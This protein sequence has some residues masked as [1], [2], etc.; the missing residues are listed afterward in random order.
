VVKDQDAEETG[1]TYWPVSNRQ[2]P[3]KPYCHPVLEPQLGDL[4]GEVYSLRRGQRRFLN[5]LLEDPMPKR[6]AAAAAIRYTDARRWLRD[7]AFCQAYREAVAAQQE[8]ASDRY[9]GMVNKALAV[10]DR[11]MDCEDPMVAL[12]AADMTLKHSLAGKASESARPQGDVRITEIVVQLPQAT[13][14][15]WAPPPAPPALEG[16]VVADS[17]QCG[18]EQCGSEQWAVDSEQATSGSEPL[19]TAHRSPPTTA[20]PL[21]TAHRSLITTSPLTIVVEE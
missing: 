12:K 13:A 9:K 3:A 2:R 8:L 18:S 14:G 11:A 20:E 15:Q 1:L 7:P 16:H 10:V 17:E 4:L 5:A 19:P 6:A 21:P